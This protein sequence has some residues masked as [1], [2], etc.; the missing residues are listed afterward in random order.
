[1]GWPDYKRGE[2]M[3]FPDEP[4]PDESP[5][6]FDWDKLLAIVFSVIIGVAYLGYLLYRSRG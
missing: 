5:R 4:P 3:G 2:G 6:D 1:M